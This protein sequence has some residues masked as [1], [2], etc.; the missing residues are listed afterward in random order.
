MPKDISLDKI[1]CKKTDRA[2]GNDFT[3]THNKKFYQIADN[4]RAQKVIVEEKTDGS[5]QIWHKNT[6]LKFKEITMKPKKI[7]QL[8]PYVFPNKAHT[9]APNH[10]WK[11]F[12]ANQQYSPYEQKEKGCQKEKELLLTT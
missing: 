1:L 2:L 7:R 6:A 3:V 10:P 12:R 11:T 9:P 4:I 8:S 5:M